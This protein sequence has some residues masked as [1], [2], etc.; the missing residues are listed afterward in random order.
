MTFLLRFARSCFRG[1]LRIVFDK[2]VFFLPVLCFPPFPY[3][4][5]KLI[6]CPK[7]IVRIPSLLFFCSSRPSRNLHKGTFQLRQT[8]A[9]LGFEKLCQLHVIHGRITIFIKVWL[10]PF[11]FQICSAET[12]VKVNWYTRP[13]SNKTILKK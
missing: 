13:D 1:C 8:I 4:Q 10:P 3:K 11:C 6:R 5:L 2:R 12:V 7:F 9:T